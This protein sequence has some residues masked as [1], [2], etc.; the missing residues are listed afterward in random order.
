MIESIRGRLLSK[1]PM[2]VRVEVNGLGYGVRI[3]VSTYDRIGEVGSEVKLFTY[4]HVRE[5][6][7]QLYGFHDGCQKTLFSMLLSVAGV[8]PRIALGVLSALSVNEV[9]RALESDDVALLTSIPGVGKKTAQRIIL[10]LKEKAPPG[11]PGDAAEGEPVPGR[12]LEDE[13]VSALVSLG[14]KRAEASKA[15]RGAV[16]ALGRDSSLEEVVKSAIKSL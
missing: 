10:D 8:G 3:P 1:Q 13:A 5:E 6:L 4:L 9:Q 16:E 2:F 7:L 15:V 12:L 11:I 14:S